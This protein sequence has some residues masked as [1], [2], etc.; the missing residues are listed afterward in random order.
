MEVSDEV[1][2]QADV[3]YIQPPVLHS[4]N[5]K[6]ECRYAAIDGNALIDRRYVEALPAG[7]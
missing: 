6:L 2:A 4:C 5:G 7:E 3:A 1:C